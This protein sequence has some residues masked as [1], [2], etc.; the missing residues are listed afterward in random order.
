MLLEV[1][2]LELIEE[3]PREL[4]EGAVLE[5]EI[6]KLEVELALRGLELE[7][8]VPNMLEVGTLDDE[9]PG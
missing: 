4:E 1:D 3:V 7:D 8:N 5:P 6:R 2:T 9:A